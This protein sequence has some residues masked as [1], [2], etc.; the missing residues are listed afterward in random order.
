VPCVLDEKPFDKESLPRYNC[1]ITSIIEVFLFQ[2]IN[3]TKK[4]RGPRMSGCGGGIAGVS[5]ARASV[6]A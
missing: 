4:L 3:I 2:T 6:G 1:Y 5:G